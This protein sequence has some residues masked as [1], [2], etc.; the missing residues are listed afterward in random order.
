MGLM[1]VPG[2]YT[3]APW[4]RLEAPKVVSNVWPRPDP[5]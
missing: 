4:A 3:G 1:E 5:C 2:G